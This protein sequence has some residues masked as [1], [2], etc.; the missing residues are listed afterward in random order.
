MKRGL[1]RDMR[2]IF[3]R[4]HDS[5]LSVQYIDEGMVSGE[6]V[7]IIRVVGQT[8]DFV[9]L[10]IDTDTA[11]V[12][13]KSYQGGAEV[14]LASLTEQYL[15]YQEFDGV[16]LPLLTRATAN[17]RLFLLSRIRKAE[18]DLELPEDIFNQ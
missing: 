16:M 1:F 17:D 7:H 9:D 8:G 2:H 6:R 3:A 5:R 14:D 4:C 12:L 11:L 10:Y 15:D 18:F 13:R